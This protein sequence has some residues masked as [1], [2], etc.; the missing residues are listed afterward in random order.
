MDFIKNLHDER[1]R[2]WEQAKALLDAAAAEGRDLSAE[3]DA[4][5]RRMSDRIDEIDSRV[6]EFTDAQARAKASEEAF[7][8]LMA[9]PANRAAPVNPDAD[10]EL[11]AWLRGDTGKRAFDVRPANGP[12][13]FRVNL[14]VGSATAGG[15]TVMTSFYDRL[16]QHLIVNSGMMSAGPTVLA[17]QTGEA[18]QVPKTTAHSSSASIVTEGSALS[19]NDPA[20]GQVTLNTYKYGFLIS[21]SHELLN[22]TSVD[23]MGYL[24]AQSG[25]ALGNGFGAHLITG[26]GTSQP[27]GV[28]TAASSGVTGGTGVTGAFTADNLIDLFYSVIA[29]YR[30][31][32]SCGWLM[33]DATV[34]AV[35]KLKDS[36]NRYI[37]EPSLVVGA[38]DTLLSKPVH[39]DPNVAAVGLSAKSVLFGDFSTYFVR[40]VESIRFERSD[41]YAFNTDL[42]TF[43]AIL[44]GDGNLIDTTGAVK[45]FVGGAT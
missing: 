25:R 5:Y 15:N 42:V 35:R 17:T 16:V 14:S 28:V 24:A 12:V 18:I 36:Q 4:Q 3:E 23:L 21:V 34:G 1:L 40:M 38:P 13:Q 6:T 20:F 19:E 22:D 9:K 31:S 10:A 33:Q 44:R 32:P 30:N 45:Y 29:P 11:R 37:W 26:T 27:K 43:R 2:T 41:D 39:T 7:A 8:A